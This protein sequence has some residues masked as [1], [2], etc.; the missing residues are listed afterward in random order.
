MSLVGT[1]AKVAIGVAIAKGVGS[2]MQGS[3]D[4]GPAASGSVAADG[5][6]GAKNSPH[7]ADEGAGGLEDMMKS[8]LGGDG[9]APSGAAALGGAGGLGGLLEQ[10]AGGQGGAAQGGIGDLLQGLTGG[11]GGA[12]GLGDLL[13]QLTGQSGAPGGAGMGDLGGLLGGLLGGAAAGNVASNNHSFGDVLNASLK[14]GGEPPVKPT[15]HQEAAAAL[16]LR[17]MVQAAKSDGAIDAAEKAKISESLK[18]ASPDEVKF[19][20]ALIAAP[21]DVQALVRD[22][23]KGLEAQVYAM[24]VMAI[25]IDNRNEVNYLRLLASGLGLPAQELQYIHTQLGVKAV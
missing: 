16:L 24:S 4:A 22:T 21:V 8:L 20:K 25:A 12:G 3:G 15:P 17:A 2:M 19:V 23:P 5:R 10:L 14:S 18:G 11:Q 9:A 1:L 13:G 7:R 6:Y